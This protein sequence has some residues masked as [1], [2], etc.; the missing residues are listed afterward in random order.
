MSIDM[1]LA[2]IARGNT[3]CGTGRYLL[4]TRPGFR[5]LPNRYLTDLSSVTADN[6][7]LEKKKRRSCEI[8][9]SEVV[10][11]TRY[12]IVVF[13]RCVNMFSSGVSYEVVE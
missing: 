13:M 6:I 9:S 5:L 11:N 7:R 1:W 3:I 8:V 4:G 10:E 2:D 12:G